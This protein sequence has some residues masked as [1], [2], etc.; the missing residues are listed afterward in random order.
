MKSAKA[1]NITRTRCQRHKLTY[2]ALHGREKSLTNNAQLSLFTRTKPGIG[3][4]CS[5]WL[6]RYRADQGNKLHESK[7]RE[8]NIK[9]NTT[10]ACNPRIDNLGQNRTFLKDLEHFARNAKQPKASNKD[11][12]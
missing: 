4:R 6:A 1:P 9:L 3:V 5:D 8:V 7:T 12:L 10:F 11:N 2:A